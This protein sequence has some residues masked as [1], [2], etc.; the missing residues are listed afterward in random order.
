MVVTL[1]RNGVCC[2]QACLKQHAVDADMRVL[3]DILRKFRD[4]HQLQ[5]V[6]RN[7][8]MA[9]GRG[10]DIGGSVQRQHG[11]I[12]H[13]VGGGEIAK[14]DTAGQRMLDGL[15]EEAGPRSR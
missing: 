13:A 4:A 3:D 15:Q 11:Y 14:V 7:A 10:V 8:V 5:V 1:I 12:V 9:L 6:R 2:G